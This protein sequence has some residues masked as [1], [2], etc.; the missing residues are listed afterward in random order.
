MFRRLE[1]VEVRRKSDCGLVSSFSWTTDIKFV[2]RIPVVTFDGGIQ[3]TDVAR[4]AWY[5]NGVI[6]EEYWYGKGLGL[7][8]WLK[9]NG[10]KSWPREIIPVGSQENNWLEV[11]PCL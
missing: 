10:N 5:V 7:V 3:V 1:S 11:I 9:S 2:E 6:E 4:L 8:Q